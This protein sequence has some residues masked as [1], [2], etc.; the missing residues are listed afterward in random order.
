MANINLY[1]YHQLTTIDRIYANKGL[2]DLMLNIEALLSSCNL[3]A[4]DSSWLKAELISGPWV[5]RYWVEATF[6]FEYKDMPDPESIRVLAKLNIKCKYE[7]KVE[8]EIKPIYKTTR[9]EGQY[10]V[11][12]NEIKDRTVW[13]VKLQIPKKLLCQDSYLDRFMDEVPTDIAD[14]LEMENQ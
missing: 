9:N 6:R 7:K 3:Y 14:D 10:Q 8:Q 1:K 13:Y 11:A 12:N 5:S 4:L 2:L